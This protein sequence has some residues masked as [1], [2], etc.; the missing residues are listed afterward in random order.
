MSDFTP[1]NISSLQKKFE[2]D[3]GLNTILI[4]LAVATMGVVSFIV[5]LLFSRY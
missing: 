5:F 2:N 4:V 1:L 3:G